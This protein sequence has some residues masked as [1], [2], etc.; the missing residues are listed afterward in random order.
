MSP[1]EFIKRIFKALGLLR[2]ISK[3][4]DFSS[5]TSG[6]QLTRKQRLIEECRKQDVSIH[7]DDPAEQSVGIYAELRGVVSEAELDRRLNTKKATTLSNR[8]NNIALL[9]FVVSVIALARFFL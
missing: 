3:E 4:T 1:Y 8:A 5:F 6:I 9:A 2:P 7:I